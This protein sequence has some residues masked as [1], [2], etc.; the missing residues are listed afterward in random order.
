MTLTDVLTIRLATTAD[1]AALL[2]LAALDCAPAPCAPVLLAE[3]A[4]RAV[5]AC[6]LTDGR[7]V[8]DPF[9]P[10][11]A[12][13]ATLRSHAAATSDGARGAARHR[14]WRSASARLRPVST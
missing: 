5:A 2:D 6:S 7:V 11:A 10:T 3:V 4:G 13:V 8:A 12:V 9:V 14:L 1:A